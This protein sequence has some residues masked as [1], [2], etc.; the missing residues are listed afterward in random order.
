MS[1]ATK[2]ERDVGEEQLLD[3]RA[4]GERLD[5]L[6]QT[7]TATSILAEESKMERNDVMSLSRYSTN[8][9]RYTENA[10]NQTLQRAPLT[11]YT[12]DLTSGRAFVCF[13]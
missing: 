12:S 11:L 1:G 4:V 3:G 13:S 10:Q 2:C 7:N 6:G 9:S 5:H 8:S